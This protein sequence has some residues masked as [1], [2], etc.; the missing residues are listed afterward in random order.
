[1]SLTNVDFYIIKFLV[2]V[3]IWR[4]FVDISNDQFN[5]IMSAI[6]QLQNNVLEIVS[7]LERIESKMTTHETRMQNL[8]F[9]NS[10]LKADED[11]LFQIL[12]NHR[13]RLDRL[14]GNS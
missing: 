14:E 9:S 5:Q 8:E 12:L 11:V 4:K 10:T 2:S 7:S 1:V 13:K 3:K 6:A